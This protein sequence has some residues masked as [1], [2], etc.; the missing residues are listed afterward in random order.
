MPR[1]RLATLAL[2]ALS[3]GGCVLKS[4]A[5]HSYD[6]NRRERAEDLRLMQR[7]TQN[8]PRGSDLAGEALLAAV[9]GK[10]LVN[11]YPPA[12]DD[13]R[14][15]YVMRQHFA[16]DGLFV[17]GEEPRRMHWPSSDDVAFR[18]RVEGARLC[19]KGPPA[20]NRRRCYRMARAGDGALQWF[21]D[22]PDDEFDGQLTIVTHEIID[23][24][25]DR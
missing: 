13:T 5:E 3:L 23:D 11:R 8:T 22:D 20:Q 9:R 15:A 25:P 17:F 21:I 24:P 4:D 10:T 2:L 1:L 16:P 14:G 7:N 6:P 19:I 12:R 18:W